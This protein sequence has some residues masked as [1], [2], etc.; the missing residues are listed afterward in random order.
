MKPD[1]NREQVLLFSKIL[2]GTILP[3]KIMG[4][5]SPSFQAIFL[6]SFLFFFYIRHL[7]CKLPTFIHKF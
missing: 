5:N 7:S 1:F 2:A 6:S 3:V 4:L